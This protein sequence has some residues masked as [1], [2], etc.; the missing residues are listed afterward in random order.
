MAISILLKP[1]K[2]GTQASLQLK[3]SATGVA[4]IFAGEGKHQLKAKG[5]FTPSVTTSTSPAYRAGA[6]II[7]RHPDSNPD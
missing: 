4:A 6:T 5:A 7:L 3:T 1:G 2:D